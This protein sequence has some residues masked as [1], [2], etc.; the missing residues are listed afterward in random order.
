MHLVRDLGLLDGDDVTV[1]APDVVDDDA[2]AARCTTPTTSRRC[3]G[4][5]PTRTHARPAPRPRH[6]RRAHLHRHARGLARGRAAPRS[7]RRGGPLEGRR[8]HAVNLAGG[9]HHAMP[10]RGRR[11][12]A[13]TTTSPSAIQWLLDHGVERVAYVDVDVHHGDGV[14][15]AFWDDPRVL[16][17]SVHESGRALFPGTGFPTEVGGPGAV[18]TAVNVALPAGHRR[19]G[20]AARLP[21]RRAAAASS[22][23]TPQI[24]VTQQGCDTHARRPARAPR[25]S[26]ST[27]SA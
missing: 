19:R 15:A 11:G 26:P 5:P 22:S 3:S 17:V 6:R 8:L 14:Q 21:R 2:A 10:G 23:F 13:S 7:P 4:P 18:G 24:L 27:A 20:L 1:I 9:L 25:R 12:S 16:T